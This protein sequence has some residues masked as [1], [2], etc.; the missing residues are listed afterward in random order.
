MRVA[1][2][3]RVGAAAGALVLTLGLGATPADARPRSHS[4]VTTNTAILGVAANGG[5]NSG[6][7]GFACGKGAVNTGILGR[8]VTGRCL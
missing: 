6:I 7:L 2:W 4:R 5:F 1:R 3:G 8:A